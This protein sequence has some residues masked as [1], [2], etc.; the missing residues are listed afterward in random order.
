MLRKIYLSPVGYF[1]SLFLN[2]VGL[3]H[4]PFM[5]YGYRNRVTGAFQKKTRIS[6]TVTITDKLQLDIGDSCWIWH[7]SI[8]DSSNGIKIGEGCQIG[9]W[10]GIFS[11]SSHIAIRL[12]GQE[13]INVARHKRIGYIREPVEIGDYTF[14]AA[15]SLILPGVKIGKGCLLAAG[16]VLSKNVPDFSIVSGNPAKVIG[17][18]TTLDSK[19]FKDPTVQSLYFDQGIIEEYLNEKKETCSETKERNRPLE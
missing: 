4:K 7:H 15:S 18:T 3:I 12:L 14:I 19:F 16:S 13:Y 9:A 6:S 1:I 2:F 5:V 10:V 11:H 17:R 8:M